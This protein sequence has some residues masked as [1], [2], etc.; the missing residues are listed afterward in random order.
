MAEELIEY[1]KPKDRQQGPYFLKNDTD[2]VTNSKDF[3]R[4]FR[5]FLLFFFNHPT[6]HQSSMAQK[7]IIV[8]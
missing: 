2:L 6:K 7:L 4:S 8:S 5:V 3:L 1:Q